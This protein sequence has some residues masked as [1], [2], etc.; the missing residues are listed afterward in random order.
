MQCTFN[1]L[2]AECLENRRSV[3]FE[4]RTASFARDVRARMTQKNNTKIE[5]LGLVPMREDLQV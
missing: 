1:E 5:D 2:G 4:C 3:I